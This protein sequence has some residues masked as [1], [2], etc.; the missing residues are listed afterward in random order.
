M[1]PSVM[2]IRSFQS[3]DEAAV[4]AL[5]RDC[6]LVRAGID[7]WKDIKRKQA[8]N[9]EMFLVGEME[10]K[11]VASVMVGYEGRRGWIN[12]LG[13]SP[14]CQRRGLGRQMM[15]EAERM[16][17]QVGCP[18]INLQVRT[19]NREVMQFYERIGF[20]VDDV[21]SMGKRLETDGDQPDCC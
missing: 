8:V 6:G 14:G 17:R 21:I 20:K 5:W 1:G 16:L 2:Q 12:Y 11:I 18:K 10:G 7:P 9:P 19:T 13:V 15:A 4:V 3:G